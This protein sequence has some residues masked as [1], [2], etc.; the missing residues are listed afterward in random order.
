M[1]SK[2]AKRKKVYLVDWT[3][4]KYPET[5]AM[6]SRMAMTGNEGLECANISYAITFIFITFS[7]LRIYLKMEPE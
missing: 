3:K 5:K 7:Y 4:S 6:R 1:K 2:I